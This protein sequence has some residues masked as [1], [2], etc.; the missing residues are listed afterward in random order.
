MDDLYA[1]EGGSSAT[2]WQRKHNARK[3]RQAALKHRRELRLMEQADYKKRRRIFEAETKA[4]KEKGWTKL[5]WQRWMTQDGRIISIG[6]PKKYRKAY[7][8]DMTGQRFGRL[9]VMRVCPT[10]QQGCQ[11]CRY[12]WV[13]CDC[14]HAEHRVSGTCLR[15]GIARSCGCLKVE[16]L[17]A[18]RGVKR[19][20]PLSVRMLT[21]A[22]K[23]DAAGEK[24]AAR[25][26]I[27]GAK[28]N[29]R[30]ERIRAKGLFVV[31]LRRPRRGKL[32]E[33]G[34]EDRATVH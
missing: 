28:A 27:L 34:V 17:R 10:S 29:S 5:P 1:L 21:M 22:Q 7:Y 20:R 2:A 13:R 16:T 24:K 6:K 12:W 18:R 15:Q 3:N 4:A 31:Q 14:G 26:L 8:K 30:E 33:I 9:T 11:R 19:A 32:V 23:L 25:L